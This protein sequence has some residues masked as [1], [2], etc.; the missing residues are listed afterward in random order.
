MSVCSSYYV[1]IESS[2]Q[3]FVNNYT[4]Q[5]LTIVHR[6]SRR[7]IYVDICMHVGG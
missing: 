3:G 6:S 4:I 5:T 2:Q 7:M 1:E